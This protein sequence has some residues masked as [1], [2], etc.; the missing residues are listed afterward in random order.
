M[1][2]LHPNGNVVCVVDQVHI[3]RLLGEGG[4]EVPEPKE[5][6]DA[7]EKHDEPNAISEARKR[8]TKRA[9][10]ASHGGSG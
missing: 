10:R 4:V 6:A 5:T 1:W 8:R 7:S 3:A 2:I 9:S